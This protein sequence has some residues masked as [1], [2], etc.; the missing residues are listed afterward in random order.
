MMRAGP[1]QLPK[2]IA[3]FR[4]RVINAI[5]DY[6]ESLTPLDSGTVWHSWTPVGVVS[7][8]KARGSGLDHRW[9]VEAA[10]NSSVTVG[11]GKIK[12]RATEYTWAQDEITGLTDAGDYIIYARVVSGAC[13]V[14]KVASTSWPLTDEPADT[15][16]PVYPLAVVTVSATDEGNIISKIVQLQFG[17][18]YEDVPPFDS[19]KGSTPEQSLG[20]N[21]DNLAEVY[22]FKAAGDKH[23]P[24]KSAKT[25]VWSSTLGKGGDCGTGAAVAGDITQGFCAHGHTHT[26]MDSVHALSSDV[27]GSTSYAT[28]AG[29]LTLTGGKSTLNHTELADMP[30]SSNADHD[31]RYWRL[32][33]DYTSCYGSSIGKTAS[34][35]AIDLSYLTL[36][37]GWACDS[38]FSV[39]GMLAV[40]E[41]G[42]DTA[43]VTVNTSS[44]FL[45]GNWACSGDF[46]VDGVLSTSTSYI[47]AKTSYCVEGT[48]VVGPRGAAVADASG[49]LIVDAEA[50]TAINTLLAR[51][52]A[53]G[54]T[55]S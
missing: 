49:G 31:G 15:G 16:W 2:R 32:G 53:H 52:R 50:R 29:G 7:H 42:P 24:F 27:A 4:S 44:L 54:L 6:L 20:V 46:T 37:G 21:S 35:I 47:N 28:T 19:W 14:D 8:A 25:L 26:I 13:Q 1:R 40:E 22:G 30:S 45:L 10:S 34:T 36:K 18:I 17:D 48:Q 55:V 9:K 3:G 12:Y 41:I 43:H 38:D 51:L 39:V 23:A 5:I 11:D 33:G